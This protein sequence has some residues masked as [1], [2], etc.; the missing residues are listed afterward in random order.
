MVEVA[1]W[2]AGVPPPAGG[3]YRLSVDEVR[4]RRKVYA[5]WMSLQLA[6]ADRPRVCTN[7]A[8]CALLAALAAGVVLAAAAALGTGDPR[9]LESE[10]DYHARVC[11]ELGK[12]FL[13]WPRPPHL[14]WALCV[15]NCPDSAAAV[16]SEEAPVLAA[17]AVAVRRAPGDSEVQITGSVWEERIPVYPTEPAFDRFCLAKPAAVVRIEKAPSGSGEA[18]RIAD[19]VLLAPL[20]RGRGGN[21]AAQVRRLVGDLRRHWPPLPTAVV[22]FAAFA[23]SGLFPL[24]LLCHPAAAATMTSVCGVAMVAAVAWSAL[25]VAQRLAVDPRIAAVAPL[26]PRLAAGLGYALL[27]LAGVMLPLLL[28]GHRM[29]RRGAAALVLGTSLVCGDAQLRPLWLLPPLVA[30]AQLLGV[31]S[32]LCLLPWSLSV[33]DVR[34]HAQGVVD[35][36][37]LLNATEPLSSSEMFEGPGPTT[38]VPAVLSVLGKVTF[39]DAAVVAINSVLLFALRTWMGLLDSLAGI[40]VHIVVATWYFTKPSCPGGPRIV[41]GGTGIRLLLHGI[42]AAVRFHLGTAAARGALLAV[43]PLPERL[44]RLLAL[45][46]LLVLEPCERRCIPGGACEAAVGC[47][48]A[49]FAVLS[50]AALGDVAVRGAALTAAGGSA[51]DGI[52]TAVPSVQCLLGFPLLVTALSVLPLSLAAL[53]LGLRLVAVESAQVGCAL[54]LIACVHVAISAWASFYETVPDAFLFCFIF[55]DAGHRVFC[56]EQRT[57]LVDAKFRLSTAPELTANSSFAL[58]SSPWTPS[59]L[60]DLLFQVS[61]ELREDSE[62]IASERTDEAAG[63]SKAGSGDQ[64]RLLGDCKE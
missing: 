41:D 55:D 13:Y 39:S 44:L 10:V 42:W 3:P 58:W 45:A 4:E 33:A 46:A 52:S 6:V 30:A 35:A 38:W 23:A 2:V 16:N 24:L 26:Q 32:W 61:E 62:R 22:V 5:A 54:V 40:A 56:N 43:L 51:V 60:R 14:D 1:P 25:S 20:R 21:V 48:Q 34:W 57:K 7:V 11:R 8:A 17:G 31:A 9:W 36:G 12:P 15:A 19:E 37:F 53:P 29:L 50:P 63:S 18:A 47:S 64:D 59:E 28:C 27:A 49:C